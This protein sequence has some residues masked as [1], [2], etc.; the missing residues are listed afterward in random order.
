MLGGFCLSKSINK[1][2]ANIDLNL[3][4]IKTEKERNDEK[5]Q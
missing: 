4:T 5:N 1:V 2:N 3:L